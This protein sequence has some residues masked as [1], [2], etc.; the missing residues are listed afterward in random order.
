MI[1]AAESIH[2]KNF[3][4]FADQET[5]LSGQG[6]VLIKGENLDEPWKGGNAVGKTALGD[7]LQWCFSGS[8][9]RDILSDSVIGKAGKGCS[10]SVKTIVGKESLV[11]SRYRKDS[12]HGN[13][14][15][16]YE[17]SNQDSSH[18]RI[19]DTEARFE[20]LLG[21]SYELVR[22]SCFQSGDPS[23]HFSRLPAASRARVL[24]E[25]VGASEADIP[26]RQRI[27]NKMLRDI[28][29]SLAESFGALNRARHE[30]DQIQKLIN[31]CYSL[32][33]RTKQQAIKQKEALRQRQQEEKGVIALKYEESI[34]RLEYEKVKATAQQIKR[35]ELEEKLRVHDAEYNEAFKKHHAASMALSRI[36]EVHK[37]KVVGS[38]CS[39]CGSIITIDGLNFLQADRLSRLQSCINVERDASAA[40]DCISKARDQ[41]RKEIREIL[42]GP[43]P[44]S[45]ENQI[46]MQK[47]ELKKQMEREDTFD[48]QKGQLEKTTEQTIQ[49]YQEQIA[50][51]KENLRRA[52]YSIQQFILNQWSAQYRSDYLQILSEFYSPSGFRPLVMDHYA[53][54]LSDC[55]NYFFEDFTSG[56][57]KITITN[58]C[59]LASGKVVDRIDIQVEEDGVERPFPGAWSTSEGGYIDLSLNLAV[60]K[61]ASERAAKQFNFLWLDEITNGI[62]PKWIQALIRVIKNKFVEQGVSVFMVSHMPVPE[63]EFDQVWTVQKK[64][65][66]SKIIF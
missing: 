20:K 31:D 33:E 44:E 23:L 5:P 19:R 53:P 22:L 37:E 26:E 1:F 55:A 46:V 50:T 3:I 2:L 4:T 30:I 62:S 39:D 14:F 27:V 65:G 38:R 54:I 17:S 34:K 48:W 42:G 35:R 29:T 40:L 16:I 9:S 66:I 28:E 21:C 25:I 36:K 10:V 51:Y 18:R 15:L 45:L 58:K 63:K 41:I 24:D 7:A 13:A 60:M 59:R 12:R 43:D 6:L 61:L 47:R 49:S 11:L 57:G 8:T 52:Q 56:K 32:I 64:D